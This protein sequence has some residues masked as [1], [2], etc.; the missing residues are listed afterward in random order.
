MAMDLISEASGSPSA[1]SQTAWKRRIGAAVLSADLPGVG[2]FLLRRNRAALGFIC[3]FCVLALMY[4]PLRLPRSYT[5]LQLLILAGNVL[6]TVAGWHALRTPA[7]E[8]PQGTRRWL[9][10][11]IPLALLFSFAHV[12]WLFRVAGM[13]AFMVP[14]TSMQPTIQ[15]GDHI[16]VDMAPYRHSSP[17]RR[18]LVVFRKEDRYLVKRVVAIGGDT[19]AG[20]DGLIFLN[21]TR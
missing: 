13:R 18:D 15:L 2:H 3:A 6:F 9:L 1:F 12:L 21:G 20:K 7:Q 11:V 10:V 17:K 16:A 19:I 4:W 14:S 8:V 5:G